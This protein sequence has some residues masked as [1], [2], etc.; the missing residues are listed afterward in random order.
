MEL[1]FNTE[2]S[3]YK[4]ICFIALILL[5]LVALIDKHPVLHRARSVA[6]FQSFKFDLSKAASITVFVC[7][8]ILNTYELHMK[9]PNHLNI[10]TEWSPYQNNTKT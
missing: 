9:N 10:L 4:K 5:L 2:H 3:T 1:P 7:L 8:E 6:A